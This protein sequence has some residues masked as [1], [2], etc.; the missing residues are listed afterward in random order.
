MRKENDSLAM[1]H[2]KPTIKD[3]AIQ[4]GVST[5]TVSHMLNGTRFVSDDVTKRIK[6]AIQNLNFKP[7]PVARSLRSGKSGF[8]GFIVSNLEN[9][10]YLSIAKGIE[11]TIEANGYRLMILDSAD[12]K[13]KEM[14]NVES[15]FTRG[16]DGLIIA[17]TYPDFEYLKKVTRPDYPLVF[18][19]RQP[20]NYKADTI[21]LENV[22]AAYSATKYLI[23]MGYKTIGFLA[24]HFGVNKMDETIKERV[25]GY[26]LAIKEAGIQNLDNLIKVSA[27]KAFT[28]NVLQHVETYKLTE[29]LI[30][31]KVQAIL[32]GNSIATVGTY[33]Y[34]RDKKI[35][36][37]QD[38]SLI[39][40]DDDLWLR[41]TTPAISS[42]V[43]PAESMGAIAAQRLLRRL[44]GE[45]LPFE[46]LRLKAEIILRES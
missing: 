10:F 26:K 3:V 8:I 27:G 2:N 1:L 33:S 16:I 29:Q 36:I 44:E 12:S 22:E 21:L 7:N 15:L 11:K 14:Y 20:S 23:S 45:D 40:F 43:Q 24:I 17:P 41:L 18:I 37:P 32:C 31:Q 30:K 42:V 34:L 13:E 19:D 6:Q 25:D 28:M 38:V 35:R 5:S 9:Y 46:C 39:T 4:A